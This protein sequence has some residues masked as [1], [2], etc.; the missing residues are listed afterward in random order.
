MSHGAKARSAHAGNE[1]R[2]TIYT[3]RVGIATA[4]ASTAQAAAKGALDRT[5][6]GEAR[7][8]PQDFVT[9]HVAAI[10]AASPTDARHPQCRRDPPIL[11]LHVRL[12]E[13][14][15]AV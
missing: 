8:S 10:S 1:L 9:H 14:E 13:V 4:S 2:Y 3:H 5:A 15:V 11:P 12:N 6:Y 7:H